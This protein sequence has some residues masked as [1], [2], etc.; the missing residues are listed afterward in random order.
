MVD[1]K[2]K[3]RKGKSK[4]GLKQ[5]QKQKQQVTVNV[6]SGGGGGGFIPFTPQSAPTFDYSLLAN[7]I[8]PAATVDVPIMAQQMA[9]ALP[10]RAAEAPT[11][12][13]SMGTQTP[14]KPPSSLSGREKAMM[15]QPE[16]E[17]FRLSKFTPEMR[18]RIAESGAAIALEKPASIRKPV[19]R[20]PVEPVSPESIKPG[21]AVIGGGIFNRPA[22][23]KS[24]R[25]TIPTEPL[26]EGGGSVR[27]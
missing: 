2:R 6:S 1:K 21:G 20:V 24:L 3:S 14:V 23:E 12:V 4:K 11:L 22:R 10:A 18:E 5:K 27:L 13:A 16:E 15:R 7:L 9:P 19:K 17:V 8:R 25:E 26:Y